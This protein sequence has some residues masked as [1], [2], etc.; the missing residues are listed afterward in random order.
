MCREDAE[1]ENDLYCDGEELCDDGVCAPGAPVVCDPIPGCAD[2]VC[3]DLLGC[4][5]GPS[6]VDTPDGGSGDGGTSA[7][8]VAGISGSGFSCATAPA[9]SATSLTS[10]VLEAL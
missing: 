5:P 7:P 8:P 6:C 10:L 9:R 1:C 3:D 2:M 4:Q